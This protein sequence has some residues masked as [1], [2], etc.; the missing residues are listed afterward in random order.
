MTTNLNKPLD[1]ITY[2]SQVVEFCDWTFLS[3]DIEV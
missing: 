2:I 1:T 3:G